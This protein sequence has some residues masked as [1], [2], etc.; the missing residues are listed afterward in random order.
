MVRE[1]IIRYLCL[2]VP[3]GATAPLWMVRRP[4]RRAAGAALL[5]FLTAFVGIGLANQVALSAG[6][7]QYLRGDGAF[8]G[9]PLDLWIGWAV[10]WGPVPLLLRL[11]VWLT[12]V[13]LGWSD[14][15]LMP[16][17]EGLVRLQHDW[18]Y[19][20]GL[21]LLV[22]LVP[23]VLIGRWTVDRRRLTGR[24]LL[25]LWTFTGLVVWLAPTAVFA[26]GDG[27]WHELWE[28]PVWWTAI[29]LQLMALVAVPALAAMVEFA[30]RGG[31]T[32]FPWDPPVRLVTTGPYAYT[33]NPMQLSAVALLGVLAVGTH[34]WAMAVATLSAVAFSGVLADHHERADLAD[35]LGAA[36]TAYDE[37][38]PP[39]RIRR[40]LYA[41]KAA[42][43]YLSKECQICDETRRWIAA[44][45][46]DD[47]RL[48]VAEEHRAADG[49][50]AGLRRALYVGPDGLR[51][52][53]LAAVARAFEH[54]G[55]GYAYL[56]WLIRLPVV[57]P[58][59]QLVT[60]AMG[61]GPRTL[62]RT[63]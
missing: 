49:T 48:C 46:P 11:P 6:W 38:V 57:R 23:A 1:A 31:G 32:P 50:V 22:G 40:R 2:M 14:L 47:L 9:V 10:L 33:A 27:G 20:E 21:A 37:Q 44:T 24:V 53:G 13:L 60:D 18:L 7:W 28:G 55:P 35:R 19:G 29:I 43:L 39:W 56:G 41:G 5:S 8:L 58:V 15:L 12:V 62:R 25:Q 16:R 42:E 54:S 34:S 3:A 4:D 17:L 52:N 63:I 26:R 45:G 51:A 30:V 61:G 59:L 36:W